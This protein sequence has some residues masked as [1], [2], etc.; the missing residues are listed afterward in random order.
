MAAAA[1][2]SWAEAGG[3][4]LIGAVRPKNIRKSPVKPSRTERDFFI[5]ETSKN[6]GFAAS[7][8]GGTF[9]S[10]KYDEGSRTIFSHNKPP[11]LSVL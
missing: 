6:I 2:L 7:H 5:F 11:P 10:E 4:K 9:M 1:G 8:G 3:A